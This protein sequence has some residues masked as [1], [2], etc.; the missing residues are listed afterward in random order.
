VVFQIVP[1]E[2]QYQRLCGNRLQS[3]HCTLTVAVWFWMLF[4][5][6]NLSHG[7]V[8]K[9]SGPCNVFYWRLCGYGWRTVRERVYVAIE[10]GPCV[11]I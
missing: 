2:V 8:I 3:V 9:E 1:C 10:I 11:L 4:R 6:W 5:A 7:F